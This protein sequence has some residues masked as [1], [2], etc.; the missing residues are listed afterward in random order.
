LKKLNP[1]ILY[2]IITGSVAFFNSMI[3]TVSSLYQVTV[4][5]LTPLQLVLVGTGLE[6]TVFLFEVPTGVVADVYSR[7]LSII[8]G[9]FIIGWGFILQGAIPQFWAIFL[10]SILWGLGYT[11]TSGA[12][13]AWISDEIGEGSARMAFLRAGQARNVGALAG[14]G[15]SVLLGNSQVNLPILAGGFSYLLLSLFL[16]LAMPERGFKP[17]PRGERSTWQNLGNTFRLGLQTV[18]GRP[19][20]AAI[21]L[22]RLFYG[23]Y[24]E[25]YDRL[26]TKHLLDSFVFPRTPDFSLVTWF[27]V[28]RAV[29]LLLSIGAIETIR[30]RQNLENLRHLASTLAFITTGLVSALLILAWTKSLGLALLSV[31]TVGVTRTLIDPLYTAWVNRRLDSR[32]RATVIS[33]SSQV[34][35]L[36]QVAGGPVVGVIG[37]LL[38]VQ[39]AITFSSMILSPVLGLYA[40]FLKKQAAFQ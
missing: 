23:L 16:L 37:N 40:R 38:S 20:L 11:F 1:L 31:W 22:I 5:Q 2:L 34:D 35:A 36:G 19:D 8:V 4:A 17:L 9:M 27:G 29:G 28:I 39:A 25:G 3:F 15:F 10:G 13:Q 7:R 26:W 30:R 18:R 33:M 32:V 21:L 24:S 12:T 14:L 6:A